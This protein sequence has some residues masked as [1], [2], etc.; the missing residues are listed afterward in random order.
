M[1]D[2]G[3]ASLMVAVRPLVVLKYLGQLLLLLTL[4]DAVPLAA[5]LFLGEGLFAARLAITTAGLLVL[6]IPLSRLPAPEQIQWN[7]ALTVTVL[8]FALA[9]LPM[10]YP[11]MA[12]G[13][14]FIDAWFEALSGVTTTGLSM[15]GSVEGRPALFLFSRA[16]MQWYG[17]LGI[18]VLSVALLMR[19]QVASKRLLESAGEDATAE[20]ARTHALRVFV[21]YLALTLL[22][23]AAV[24]VS[25]HDFLTAVLH[26]LAAVSTGGFSSFNDSIAGMPSAA[27]ATV[28]A[29]SVAGAISLP[30]YYQLARA[31]WRPVSSDPE[32]RALMVALVVIV[33]A[34]TLLL[35][36]M[37]GL[38]WSAAAANGLMLG[39]SAQ[40]TAGFSSMNVTALDPGAKLVL[41]V[42]MTIGGCTG[43]TAGGIKLVRL[44]ILL[45]LIQ[46]ALR[47]S[48]A[49]R[50]AIMHANLGGE[51]L[52]QEAITD[53]LLLLGLWLMVVVGSWFPFLLFGYDPLNSLFEVVSATGT[54]GLSAG[55]SGPTLEPLLKVVLGMDMLFG[56]VEIVALL[57]ILYPPT[58]I[59]RRR[60]RK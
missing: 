2:Q 22:G 48:A 44:L 40:T 36:D 58:W 25:D 23:L 17:G 9:P 52:E 29:V 42:A 27:R 54:V 26:T 35:H 34:L 4:L 49:P 39:A 21:A 16:W 19:H 38:D 12:H 45:R 28:T 60:E 51:R 31:R 8:A 1:S 14:S 30:L 7:E 20:T 24:W 43:S 59:G 10:A 41:V 47:R 11:M 32:L 18:A 55:I 50:R 37:Q 57:V 13:I 33:S 6:S 56:R 15:L 53:A 5:S 3:A 46:I